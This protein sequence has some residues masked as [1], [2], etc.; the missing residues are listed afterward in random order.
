MEEKRSLDKDPKVVSIL[1]AAFQAFAMY[2]FRRTSMED[3]AKGAGISRA[4][5]Y[6][7]FKNKDEIFRTLVTWYYHDAYKNVGEA[8]IK[9]GSVTDILLAAFQAQSGPAFKVLLDSPHGEELLDS[10]RTGAGDIVAEG[11]ARIAGLYADWL[12]RLSREGQVD[13]ARVSGSAG[14]IADA[15]MSGLRGAKAHGP[16]FEDYARGRDS[17]ARLFGQ[18]LAV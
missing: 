1:D 15:M 5:V 8:L 11:E 6:Q 2:G 7:H 4:A 3:I 9:N 14:E 10:K 16:S 18:G 12:D 13:L 17:L